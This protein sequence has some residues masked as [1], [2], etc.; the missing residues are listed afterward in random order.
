[1]RRITVK[2][3][4]GHEI[5]SES[6]SWTSWWTHV[7]VPF[8][9]GRLAVAMRCSCVCDFW[10]NF[11]APL[12]GFCVTLPSVWRPV[13]MTSEQAL[14]TARGTQ[15]SLGAGES[16]YERFITDVTL[17]CHALSGSCSKAH[18]V[19][20]FFL[21]LKSSLAKSCRRDADCLR[22]GVDCGGEV[23]R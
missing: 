22:A 16:V 21:W 20:G 9:V 1:M 6:E 4:W 17:I 10:M 13:E 12:S 19:N 23:G 14:T 8:G 18:I 3:W 15:R 7:A 11:N 2:N 5:D